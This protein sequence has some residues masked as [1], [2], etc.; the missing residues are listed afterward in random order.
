V[1]RG[2]LLREPR[3]TGGFGYDPLFLPAGHD[4]TSAELSPQEKDAIS[5]RGQ[6]FRALG[7]QLAAALR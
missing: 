3:G 6:A 7:P 5:H 4:R 2:R 1:L